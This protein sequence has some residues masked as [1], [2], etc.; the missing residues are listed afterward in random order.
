MSEKK[1]EKMVQ[2]YEFQQLLKAKKNFIIPVTIFFVCFFIFLPIMT[3]YTTV[4]NKPCIGSITW[5]WMIAFLQFVMT[6]ILAALYTKKANHF[7]KMSERIKRDHQSFG[8]DKKR[9]VIV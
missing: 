2:T 4:L 5:A 9:G 6:W 8:D 1:Y 3:S 7:D